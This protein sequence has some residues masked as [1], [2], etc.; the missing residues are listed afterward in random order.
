M[1]SSCA[2]CRE[3]VRVPLGFA[4]PLAAQAGLTDDDKHKLVQYCRIERR[5]KLFPED[6]GAC[7]YYKWNRQE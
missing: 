4:I 5:R 2:T 1:T 7:R 3:L 6:L